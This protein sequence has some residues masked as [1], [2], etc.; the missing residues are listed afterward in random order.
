MFLPNNPI[1][2][3]QAILKFIAFFIVKAHSFLPNLFIA[4]APKGFPPMWSLTIS[5]TPFSVQSHFLIDSTII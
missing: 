3:Y 1:Q 4:A 5:I 2:G